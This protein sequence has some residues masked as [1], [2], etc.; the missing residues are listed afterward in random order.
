MAKK[1]VAKPAGVPA[2]RPTGALKPIN[3]QYAEDQSFGFDEADKDSYAVPFLAILQAGSPQVKKSDGK[4]IKGAEEGMILNTV[5]Q[6]VFSGE[7]GEG[8]EVVPFYF[9]QRYTRWAARDAGGGFR[10]EYLSTDPEL[11]HAKGEGGVDAG[12]SAARFFPD[13]KGKFDK[14]T[15]DLLND[16]RN[17]YV[18][19][20][21]GGA[22]TP[23]V[24]S[25]M[26]TQIRASKNWMAKM[27]GMT[28]VGTDGHVFILP[29][30]SHRFRLT[31]TPEKNDKGSWYGWKV[32][33]IGSVDKGS[34]EYE[35]AK[36][37][38]KSVSSGTLKTVQPEIDP[39]DESFQQQ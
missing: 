20:T 9:T 8:I 10:G 12:K 6:E 39:D 24:V 29:M 33:L 15:S 11:K 1:P 25:M 30:C 36:N 18:L 27:R 26:S 32:E 19:F 22:M 7:E 37:L 28:G 14:K 34:A 21:N 35:A 5:T 31:T 4:F 3:Q 23:A 17:H 2:V 16:T 13:A 38:A